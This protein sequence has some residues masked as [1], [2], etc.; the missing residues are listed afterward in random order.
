M[1]KTGFRVLALA[2]AALLMVTAFA[3]C[4]KKEK[5]PEMKKVQ[6]VYRATELAGMPEDLRSI[7]RIFAADGNVYLYGRYYDDEWTVTGPRLY[8]CKTDGSEMTRVDL[9]IK[10][11]VQSE[12]DEEESDSGENSNITAMTAENANATW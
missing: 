6:Y 8:R 2:L 1:K 10:D 9:G 3:G 7:E 5:A 11:T 4:A 12:M